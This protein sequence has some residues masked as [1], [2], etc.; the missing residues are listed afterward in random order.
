VTNA[1]ASIALHALAQAKSRSGSIGPKAR[2]PYYN[3]NRRWLPCALIAES[4]PWLAPAPA[5]QW[6]QNSLGR[7]GGI[8]LKS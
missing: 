4:I 6:R 7:C 1:V 8:G 5:S 3:L 2:R